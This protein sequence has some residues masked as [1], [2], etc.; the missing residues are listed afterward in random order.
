MG[1]S[2]SSGCCGSC[3]AS[4]EVPTWAALKGEW[5]ARGVSHNGG[6]GIVGGLGVCKNATA[7]DGVT[8]DDGRFVVGVL[9]KGF[10]SCGAMLPM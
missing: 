10:R 5:D 1:G 9:V 6:V 2:S 7:A 8:R 4:S 3:R